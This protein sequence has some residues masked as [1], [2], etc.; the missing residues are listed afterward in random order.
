MPIRIQRK[1]AKG[2][3][4]FP[5]T[6]YVGRPSKW[7]N[8]YKVD[9]FREMYGQGTPEQEAE[10]LV[11]LYRRYITETR[12]ELAAAAKVE[13][14]GRNLVCWCPLDQECHADVLLALANPPSAGGS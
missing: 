2:W 6:I 12:P 4:M 10:Y 11:K 7:G 8:P 5:G 14:A 1:R 3:R 9:S 13:L